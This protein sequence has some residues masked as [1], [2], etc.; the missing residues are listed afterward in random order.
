MPT[1]HETAYLRLKSSISQRELV[2]LYTPTQAELD[3]ASRVAKGET[4]KLS[5]LVL[6]KTFQ[7]LGYFVTLENVPRCVVEH[8]GHDRGM[9]I[10]ADT[11]A[12]YDE[13]GTRRRHVAMIRKY[14]RVRSFDEAGQALL[15]S[16]IRLAAARMED[17]SDII[18]VAIEELVRASFELPGFST[19]HPGHGEQ[20]NCSVR[21]F[22][23]EMLSS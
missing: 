22:L 11:L 18:N 16:S 15:A 8:I 12:E 7:R 14:L 19:L 3:L 17:L 5:F 23:P 1:V 21:L 4:A 10:V 9:L 13:S 2:D 6:L 20:D